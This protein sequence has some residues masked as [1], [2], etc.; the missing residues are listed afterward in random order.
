MPTLTLK[1]QSRLFDVD[2]KG[3]FSYLDYLQNAYGAQLIGRFDGT[4]G[5]ALIPERLTWV[6]Q[7]N[8]GQAQIDP[9]I[10]VTPDQPSKR[11]LC[12]HG[13]GFSL[14]IWTNV[15]RG[16]DCALCQNHVSDRPVRQ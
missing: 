10:A 4:G 16:F 15:F 7:E 14:K 3:N 6:L 9:F 8:F 2:A 1:Q 11:Q 12:E 5:V 13:S